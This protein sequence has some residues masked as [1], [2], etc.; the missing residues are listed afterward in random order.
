MFAQRKHTLSYDLLVWHRGLYLLAF[1]QVEFEFV[2]VGC[3]DY[4]DFVATAVDD[5]VVYVDSINEMG[6]KNVFNQ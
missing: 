1:L 5:L 2:C 3:F 4:Y 6:K